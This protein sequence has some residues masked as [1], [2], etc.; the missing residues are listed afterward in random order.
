MV[1]AS[2]ARLHA[3][4]TKREEIL[5]RGLFDVFP[6]NPDDPK[7]T[8][9][10]NL[11]AS[12][13]RV[14]QH[15]APD[16]MAVQK[17]DIRR[18]D[19]TG[20]EF[21]ERF[22]SPVNSPVLDASG[23]IT[24]IIHRV[25][26]VTEFIRLKYKDV[27]QNKATE[28]LQVH[29]EQMESEIFLR[30]RQLKE[31]NEK[32]QQGSERLRSILDAAYNAFIAMDAEGF[33]T[34]WNPQA[35]AV[36]GWSKQEVL[37]R[38]LADT[39]IPVAFRQAHAQGLKKFLVTGESLVLGKR[40]E[41][42]VL[43]KSG[44]EL[45]VELTISAIKQGGSFVF[46]AFLHDISERKKIANKLSRL[47]EELETRV[48]ERT[49]ELEK[50]KL[51]ADAANQTKSAFLANMSHEIRTP[52]G[53]V[54]GFSELLVNPEVSI[55]DKANFIEAI[56]RNGELLSQIIN[57]ILD[58]SRV[59]AG[60]LEIERRETAVNEI[61]ADISL[62]NL[63]A[64]EKGIKLSISYEKNVPKIIQTDPLRLKQILMNVIGNAI[65]FTERGSVDLTL[66]LLPKNSQPG[67]LAVVVKDTGQGISKEQA[68][69]LFQP[70]SQADISTRRRFG[71]TGLGLALSR[72]LA[73]LLGGDVVLTESTPQKGS[74]FTITIDPG[75]TIKSPFGEMG[76][77]QKIKISP[78]A[79]PEVRLDGIRV[80]VA[81]DSV[82]N[83]ILVGRFLQMAGA[84]VD[85][86]ENGEIA[87]EKMRHGKYDVV[88]MDLQMPLKDGYETT[89]ELRKE[90][91]KTP[92]IALTAHALKEE[93]TRCL[94]SGFDEHISKPI[95]RN[96]LIKN[97]AQLCSGSR[98]MN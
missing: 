93:R 86:A 30:G 22:W 62:L 17:Y 39:I 50:A 7:A 76:E 32:L 5:G 58:L 4:M 21:E 66:K 55:S 97:I 65:K 26:D 96:V 38:K 81:E 41:L 92:I 51:A 95:D 88:L 42:A 16:A 34:D 82:D 10:A 63:K 75:P 71:G 77:D 31:T 89:A 70:F 69:R 14:I 3:T 60:K 53:V 72:H 47:N 12:L 84:Q 8:G 74:T 83:Q 15:K 37:G 49:E 67:N 28:S 85:M 48:K 45:P 94:V 6:D 23:E 20:G 35:E 52:L 25:E 68:D 80:L 91:F 13:N 36:F 1:A 79:E 2:N 78:A 11:L 29:T 44:T 64:S 40:L 18:S 27:A 61:L 43:N 98:R 73:V 24:H 90:G 54:L 56:K 57:D 33:I 9:V 87:L 46:F 59:E 19:S